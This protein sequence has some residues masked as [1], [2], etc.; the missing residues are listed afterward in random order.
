MNIGVNKPIHFIVS[1]MCCSLMLED[2]IAQSDKVLSEGILV[3]ASYIGAIKY[4]GFQLGADYQLKERFVEKKKKKDRV[5]TLYKRRFIT[6]NIG[7][8]HHKYFNT[9]T[10]LLLGYQ[11]KKVKASGWYTLFEPQVGL[12]R[13]FLEGT[14]SI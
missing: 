6:A 13:T 12:S 10:H 11:L 9:N 7:F 4:T 3:H 8:Y 14:T 5:K 1:F 2:V